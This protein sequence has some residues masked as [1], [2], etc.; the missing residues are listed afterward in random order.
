MFSKR[1]SG[2]GSGLAFV[3][4]LIT[5]AAPAGAARDLSVGQNPRNETPIT[6][7]SASSRGIQ[8]SSRY[9][10]PRTVFFDEVTGRGLLVKVW[11]NGLGPYT[12]ALD[13]GAGASII[14]ARVAAHAGVPVKQGSQNR[15]AG[16]SGIAHKELTTEVTVTSIAIGDRDN[17]LPA[18]GTVLKADIFPHDIDGLLDPTEAFWPLG[19]VIDFPRRE[20][21][22]F[23]P[24]SAPLRSWQGPGEGAIVP[25]VREANGRRPYVS[26]SNGDRALIDTGT[27]FSLAVIDPANANTRRTSNSDR[28]VRDVGGGTISARPI[29][30][31]TVAI[32]SLMLQRIPTDLVTGAERGSPTLLGR[33]ALRPFRIKFDPV[34]RLIEIAPV[35]GPGE[36]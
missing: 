4:G 19:Y 21:S 34:N 32:G 27:A 29:A 9:R 3:L 14:S 25:W 1:A 12:F 24:A 18:T 6:D 2:I 23:D 11:I 30:P 15:I 33:A 36:R 35:A 8:E 16:L 31:Q 20:L 28:A 26:L 17:T 10:I 22:A 7:N 5:W 13:T